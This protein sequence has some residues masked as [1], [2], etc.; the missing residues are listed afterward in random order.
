MATAY[1]DIGYRGESCATIRGTNAS[2]IGPANLLVED[3]FALL[4]NP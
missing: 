3:S 4:L 1:Q 2:P